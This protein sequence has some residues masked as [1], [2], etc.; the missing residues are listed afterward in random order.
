MALLNEEIQNQVRPIL[1][2]MQAP[3]KLLM[4]TQGSGGGEVAIECTMCSETRQLAEEIAALSDKITLE[5]HDFVG[6]KELAENFEIDKIP[7][8]AVLKDGTEPEDYGI[9][10]YGIPSGYEFSSFIHDILLV[11]SGAHELSPA[12]LQ[13]LAR[14]DRP[15]HI[16][17]YVTPT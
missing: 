12:T 10:L 7:A 8:L 16:Q 15:V 14:L 1:A 13:E 17:V 11:S 3:V 4:F 6:D 2:G 9:R 5:V